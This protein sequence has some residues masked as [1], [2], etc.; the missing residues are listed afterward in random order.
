[1]EPLYIN[2]FRDAPLKSFTDSPTEILDDEF[3][4]EI[5]GREFEAG[6]YSATSSA[7]WRNY[8]KERDHPRLPRLCG[9]LE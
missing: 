6:L 7:M 4:Y 1:M 8:A 2:N 3:A 5:A 9:S